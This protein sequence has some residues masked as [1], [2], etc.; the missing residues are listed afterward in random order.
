MMTSAPWADLRRRYREILGGREGVGEVHF[1]IDALGEPV[2]GRNL[3]TQA[4]EAGG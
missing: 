4:V 3:F 2:F 1:P